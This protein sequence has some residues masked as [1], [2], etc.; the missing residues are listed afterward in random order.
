MH[1]RGPNLSTSP[2][3]T[4]IVYFMDKQQISIKD[5]HK[6]FGKVTADYNRNGPFMFVTF[7]ITPVSKMDTSDL[8]VAAMNY[9]RAFV[10]SLL[11]DAIQF[12]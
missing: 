7:H 3:D 5:P 11:I 10:S 4:A 1:K 8:S 12:S 6:F 2:D 9:K